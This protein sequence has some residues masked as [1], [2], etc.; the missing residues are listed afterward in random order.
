LRWAGGKR[1]LL[2][3]IEKYFIELSPKNKFIEPFAGAGTIFFNFD[4]DN[5]ILNDINKELM[6]CYNILTSRR[7][8]R[9]L[10]DELKRRR[11][12]NT[13]K[14]FLY[15]RKRYNEIRRK[16][17]NDLEKVALFLYLN[18]TCFN[19]LYRE[20]AKGDFNTSYG[21]RF[22]LKFPQALFKK[23]DAAHQYMTERN[24]KLYNGSYE[25]VLKKAR[26][27]DFIYLD[28]PYHPLD[29]TSFTKYNKGDFSPED[30][31]KLVAWCDKLD[32]LGCYVVYSNSNSKFI[33]DLFKKLPGKWHKRELKAKRYISCNSDSR[34]SDKKIELLMTNF[35]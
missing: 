15:L 14:D 26:S 2:P 4:A 8:Y 23:L 9:N 13:E 21:K 7:M 10:K 5:N 31:R 33:K 25:T 24:V 16:K 11:Y 18:A 35:R 6:N 32:K 28:P 17:G 12:R 19:G 22:S 3:E 27:G 20:N 1:Q 30:Q 29:A 34:S